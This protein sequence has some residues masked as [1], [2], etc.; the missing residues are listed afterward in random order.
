LLATVTLQENS[1]NTKL[2][3]APSLVAT[4]SI[5]AT[6]NVGIEVPVLTS[7][8]AVPG[9]TSGTGSLVYANSISEQDSGV[10][11]NVLARVNS[12]G[13]V[14]MIVDQ[15]VSTPQPSQYGVTNSPQFQKRSV[16]TQVT[17]QDGDTI[18]ISGIIQDNK[19]YSTGGI[20]FLNRIPLI[21]AVFGGRSYSDQR[22]ELLIFLTPRVI[23]DT[24]Q[25]QDATDEL[26]DRIRHASA[27]MKDNE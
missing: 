3:S 26:R 7:T 4:D 18:A 15:E 16:Q 8:A 22:T 27:L 6:M 21:G 1:G 19:T 12:S 25:L 17:C 20:P 14:T 5:P 10:T 23:Y 24:N 11:M 9:L 2:I 13:V